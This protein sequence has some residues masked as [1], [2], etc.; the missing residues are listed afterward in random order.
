MYLWLDG[1]VFGQIGD[2]AMPQWMGLTRWWSRDFA[3]FVVKH[4]PKYDWE[5]SLTNAF[6]E[7]PIGIWS[8]FQD[9]LIGTEGFLALDWRWRGK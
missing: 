3:R 7:R 2:L 4:H 5:P 6:E 9:R 1:V 8:E